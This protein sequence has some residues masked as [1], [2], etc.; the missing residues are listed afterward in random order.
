MENQ[1]E[2]LLREIYREAQ[3]GCE[4]VCSI[5]SKTRDRRLLAATARQMEMYSDCTTRAEQM[6]Q[7]RNLGSGAF[8]TWDR[9]SLRGAVWL[10]TMDIEDGSALTDFLQASFRDSAARMRNTVARFFGTDCDGDALA[11]GRRLA[12]A[13]S[14]EA[15]TMRRLQ[16]Q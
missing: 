12:A 9:L 10:E 3:G 11:L 1:T 13:E 8:S 2:K 4:T 16:R 5:A 15:E 7:D 14:A 6:L